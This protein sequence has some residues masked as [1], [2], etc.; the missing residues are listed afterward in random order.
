MKNASLV[1]IGAT[2]S[3]LWPQNA[4]ESLAAEALQPS[5]R[6][7]LS[8][9]YAMEIWKG[10]VSPI[11]H[12]T[13][14]G[15]FVLL[16]G[17]GS[18]G[19]PPHAL[20]SD[21]QGRTWR[22]W[23]GFRT[24]P[25]MAY[26][27]VVR[28][29]GEL[30]AFGFNDRDCYGGTYL[31]WSQD[32]GLAWAG[33][34]RL[35]ADADR[36]APMNNRVLLTRSGRLVLPIEQLLGAEGPG[37]NR[38]GTIISDDGGRSW[39]RSPVFGPPPPLPDR[40]EGFGEPS[41]VELA[42]GRMW[43]VFRTRLGHLWQAWSTDGGASWGTPS[44]TGLTSPLSAVNAKR[45]PGSAAV[46]VFWNNARP[47]TTAEWGDANNYWRPRSPLACAVSQDNCQTWSRPLIVDPGTAAYPS[48]AFSD[49]EMLVAYWADPDP[50]A[51]YLNPKSDLMLVVYP[52]QGLLAGP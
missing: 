26:A 31:W 11:L 18:I 40:P 37:P 5:L 4:T 1:L 13:A 3:C 51:V 49:T 33:G 48:L 19:K 52:L 41:T 46:I 32:E 47:G 8:Q 34:S 28:R 12:R 20:L 36:W 38:I 29:G 10:E 23:E 43:M 39:Q 17:N 27:D 15:Q 25:R 21:D 16:P 14:Q 50:R 9:T 42:D 22:E 2:V 35:T 24:W 44:S 45:L 30:L 7:N 6:L